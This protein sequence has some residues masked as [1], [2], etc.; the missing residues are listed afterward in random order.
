M[1]AP[2][3][4]PRFEPPNRRLMAPGPSTADIRV[5][6]A[7]AQPVIGHLDPAAGQLLS[8]IQAM[9]RTV[10]RTDNVLTF[11]VS[12]TGTAGMECA[13]MNVLEPGDVALLVVGGAFAERM[14]EIARRCGAEVHVIGGEWGRPVADGEVAAALA[15]HRDA[16][17]VGVVH[18]ETSTGVLQPLEGIGGLCRDHGA[19]LVVDAVAS[20]GG[21][22][23]EADAWGID[24]CYSGSQKCLSVPPGLAPIT[25]SERAVEV[26]AARATPMHSFYLDVLPIS[27]YLG[28]ERLY[29]HTA[30]I[31][32]LYGLHEGL[33]MVLEE[34]LE[35]RWRRHA[36]LGAELLASLHDRGFEPYAPEGYRLPEVVCVRL[37]GW[38]DDKPM[39]RRLLDEFGIEVAGGLGE[40]AGKVWRV[41]LMGE[42]CTRDNIEAVLAGIDVLAASVRPGVSSS[43]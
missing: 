12:G 19:M 33:R 38:V 1:G 41:G 3:I 8:E 13:L 21:I 6:Q 7:M 5:R 27:Q 34:G 2:A 29:H 32:M 24:V 42:S 28:S 18:A 11:P 39:R 37:P 16:K 15:A 14:L 20:L 31:S 36:E 30:P 40:L 4:P 26:R 22:P 9:L 35:P 43:A 10:F 17:I 23:V 25:F